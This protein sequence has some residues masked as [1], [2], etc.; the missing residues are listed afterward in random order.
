M[1]L[2]PGL[3]ADN[4]FLHYLVPTPKGLM[5]N[6]FLN[7]VYVEQVDR[8]GLSVLRERAA[9]EEFLLTLD[10][11]KELWSKSG[12]ELHG[13]MTFLTSEVRYEEDARLCCVYDTA[14]TG[15]PSHA[16]LMAP[17]MRVQFP[18]LTKGE[19]K[20]KKHARIKRIVDKI[21]TQFEPATTFREG[22]LI[23]SPQV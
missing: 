11:L 22:R 19:I 3:V 15:K 12:R 20:H 2:S 7:P 21:G 1:S 9:D 8:N 5:E 6:G 14:E 17:D 4:E 13:V 16:E 18:D 23:P 10:Q